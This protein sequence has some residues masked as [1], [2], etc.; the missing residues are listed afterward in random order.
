MKIHLLYLRRI[1]VFAVCICAPVVLWGGASA[2][3]A[4]PEGSVQLS[5]SLVRVEC[6]PD[7]G[8]LTVTDLRSKRVWR[9]AW[10]EP[11]SP[12]RQHVVQTDARNRSVIMECVLPGVRADG[13]PGAVKAQLKVLLHPTRP[14]LEMTLVV[15]DNSGWRNVFYPYAFVLDGESVSN[16]YPH[17]E[18]LMV[19]ARKSNP[20]WFALPDGV[21]YGG[22]NAYLMCLG[23]VDERSGEGLLTLLPDMEATSIRWRDV[24]VGDQT[25]VTPQ[26]EWK[27]NKGAFDRPWR[28]TQSFSDRDGYVAL[29]RRYRQFFSD[30]GLRKTL[31]EKAEANPAVT[32]IAGAPI[33]WAAARRPV[34]TSAMADIL[35]AQGVDRCLFAMANVPWRKSDPEYQKEMADAIR[36]IRSLGFHVYRYDQYRDA[37]KPDAAKPAGHQLNTEAWPDKLVRRANGTAVAAFG[38]ESGIVCPHYFL[39]MAKRN[40]DLAFHEFDYSGWFLDCLGSVGFHVEAECHDP[41]HPCDRYDT[42]RGREDLLAELNR[43]GKLAG[44]ECG[45]DYL[46]PYVHWFEGATTLVRWKGSTTSKGV[47]AET[48]L[49]DASGKGEPSLLKQL[50]KLPPTADPERTVSISTRYRIPFYSLCHHDEVTVSW[51]WEDGMESPPVYWQWKNLWSVLYGAPPMYRIPAARLKE[52]EEQIGQ[53]QRYVSD[54]VRQVASDAMT[55]HRFVTS[56]RLVQE[57]EFSSGRGVVVNFGSDSFRLPGGQEVKGRDYVTFLKAGTGERIY[58]AAPCANVF[59]R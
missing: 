57:T 24:P 27:S 12:S 52:Y 19:P 13:K 3:A 33:F 34:E 48:G 38:P 10:L 47:V 51:R 49:N 8:A 2:V 58:S 37:F 18:G 45:L 22:L 21:L 15:S 23:L 4:T 6:S 28:I 59:A 43:R 9:Q 26:L 42:R 17:A 29:A 20:D 31:K 54:W 55:S 16:L 53:T 5:N 44:T 39:P 25:V 41:A 56:D 30:A 50:A 11:G 32:Q 46:I 14:D 35:K 36:H 7:D 1:L 40:L